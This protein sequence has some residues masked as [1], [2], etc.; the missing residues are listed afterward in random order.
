MTA[1]YFSTMFPVGAYVIPAGESYGNYESYHNNTSNI[2]ATASDIK[3]KTTRG[4]SA[5][6]KFFART[7]ERL[8]LRVRRSVK[9][10]KAWKGKDKEV[11]V[12]IGEDAEDGK[13]GVVNEIVE[14]S[15]V[16]DANQDVINDTPGEQMSNEINEDNDDARSIK[17]TISM[18]SVL[19]LYH[20]EPTPP[21]LP[22]SR[23]VD[24]K[25]EEHTETPLYDS[26]PEQK[27]IM[28][29]VDIPCGG[30]IQSEDLIMDDQASDC[31]SSPFITDVS[32]TDS[33]NEGEPE[34]D[35]DIEDN[36]FINPVDIRRD[37]M[38]STDRMFEERDVS[39]D[40]IDLDDCNQSPRSGHE[41]NELM[42]DMDVD[43]DTFLDRMDSFS[44]P[45]RGNLFQIDE[46]DETS[47]INEEPAT[48]ESFSEEFSPEEL[49]ELEQL[50]QP[51]EP[52]S[53]H[54]PLARTKSVNLRLR[55]EI[56]ENAHHADYKNKGKA[57]IRTA[58]THKSSRENRASW[59]SVKSTD[60]QDT[61]SPDSADDTDITTPSADSS[62]DDCT[63]E[64]EQ[65]VAGVID[66]SADDNEDDE[67]MS[68]VD[69]GY[70]F[71]NLAHTEKDV[72]NAN[73]K[74]RDTSVHTTPETTDLCNP[75]PAPTSTYASTTPP[76]SPPTTRDPTAV[77]EFPYTS[78]TH[79]PAPASDAGAATAIQNGLDDIAE[80]TEE[81]LA[82]DAQQ[83]PL[84]A[85]ET[86]P[87]QNGQHA[88]DKTMRS[89]SGSGPLRL[90][91]T[92][93]CLIVEEED[94]DN[95]DFD[96]Y[97]DRVERHAIVTDSGEY[98]GD[99]MHVDSSVNNHYNAQLE[100]A[101]PSDEQ[102]T[103]ESQESEDDESDLYYYGWGVATS[104]Y[105]QFLEDFAEMGRVQQHAN[106]DVRL[107]KCN[108]M[109]LSEPNVMGDCS[110]PL[111][112]VT[113]PEGQTKYPQD[114]TWYDDGDEE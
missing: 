77:P 14:E 86:Q 87:S 43:N 93:L 92:K 5:L 60:S 2:D 106:K 31:Q 24:T 68:E 107:S 8:T 11:V 94:A 33:I 49:E 104:R 17:S 76:G 99:P 48:E 1:F 45:T 101:A 55:Y 84:P 102:Q 74:V 100:C 21:F 28:E 80:E 59:D 44:T 57:V 96:L 29:T 19:G 65:S 105:G 32:V 83:Q 63:K 111:L 97:L 66:D 67:D 46:I 41:E 69:I 90:Y 89:A 52:L 72:A 54:K 27:T 35:S 34:L 51:E 42:F 25:N 10:P 58:I 73:T 15:V 75:A 20:E 103:D 50:G 98:T 18:D 22:Q 81:E 79:T 91:G 6:K 40:S 70:L 37:N 95:E 62:S 110:G 38:L 4:K 23:A 78:V 108:W 13:T 7:V 109:L 30:H 113:T 85:Q 9:S 53:P 61:W 114:I 12:P 36:E 3:S 88:N 56:Q 39:D 64:E 47:D 16:G 82:E 26:T 112:M 71:P